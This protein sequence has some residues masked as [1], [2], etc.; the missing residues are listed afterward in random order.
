M[1][2]SFVISALSASLSI[3]ALV[4]H[5]L[6]KEALNTAKENQVHL[7]FIAAE[8]IVVVVFFSLMK[9][10]VNG[11]VGFQSAFLVMFGEYAIAFWGCFIVRGLL[12]PLGIFG[13]QYLRVKQTALGVI[14]EHTLRIKK[15][16]LFYCKN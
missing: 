3:T 15:L 7:L 5:L 6:N 12:L 2:I 8:L 9:V 4:S 14:T 16:K 10:G 11:P 13:I 1:P